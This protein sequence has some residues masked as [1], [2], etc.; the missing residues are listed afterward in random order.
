[1]NCVVHVFHGVWFARSYQGGQSVLFFVGHD[2][3]TC[4]N[5][6]QDVSINQIN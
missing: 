3:Q 1:M 6:C 4:H 5:I 2:Q